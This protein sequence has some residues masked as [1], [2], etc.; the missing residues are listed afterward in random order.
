MTLGGRI[1]SAG[2]SNRIISHLGGGGTQRAESRFS[3]GR[4]QMKKMLSSFYKEERN[5]ILVRKW[6][7][8]SRKACC[9]S[10]GERLRALEVRPDSA[11]PP[12]CRTN[13]KKA[14]EVRVFPTLGEKKLLS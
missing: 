13:G 2:G 3:M 11:H 7:R 14:R 4:H 1:P 9:W 8:G 6:F 5:L 10:K 12:R